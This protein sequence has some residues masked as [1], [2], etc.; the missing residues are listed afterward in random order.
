MEQRGRRKE[1]REGVP[2]VGH[3]YF[4]FQ[5]SPFLLL[6]FLSSNNAPPLLEMAAAG[7]VTVDFRHIKMKTLIEIGTT[8][9]QQAPRE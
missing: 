5:F 8:E 1:V 7:A 3:N 2:T 4:S 6:S 9:T